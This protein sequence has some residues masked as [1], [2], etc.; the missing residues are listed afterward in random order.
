MNANPCS[1]DLILVIDDNSAIHEVFR[2]LLR[3]E[4][5][6]LQP[7]GTAAGQ[8]APR[9]EVDGALRGEEGLDKVQKSL[10]EG[11]PYSM[12][13][14]EV[15]MSNGWHGIEII[16]RLWQVDGNLL[17]VLCT[18]FSD[19]SGE[20]LREQLGYSS[21]LLILRKPFEPL[22]V[23]QLTLALAERARSEKK[24]HY[25][26]REHELA[27]NAIGDGIHTLD[28]E[29]LITFENKD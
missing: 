12:A 18:E 28:L 26:H 1:T 2:N 9:F 19:H 29:V 16:R 6:A 17:I 3:L 4:V 7:L 14:V 13:Y 25:L 27:L 20:D 15:R 22:E 10:R 21:R 24:L 5:S 8:S 11:R 23:R